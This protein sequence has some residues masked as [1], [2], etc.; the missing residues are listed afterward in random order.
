MYSPDELIQF[1]NEEYKIVFDKK[2]K[3]F[4]NPKR[5]VFLNNILSKEEGWNVNVA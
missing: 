2:L 3:I 4:D 5:E 1:L